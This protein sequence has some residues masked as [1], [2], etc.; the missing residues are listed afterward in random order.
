[1]KNNSV[2]KYDFYKSTPAFAIQFSVSMCLL[3]MFLSCFVII[4]LF[5]DYDETKWGVIADSLCILL[6]LSIYCCFRVS[7]KRNQGVFLSINPLSFSVK[8]K[9]YLWKDIDFIHYSKNYTRGAGSNLLI[10]IKGKI[11]PINI[12]LDA[13]FGPEEVKT[14]IRLFKQYNNRF[15]LWNSKFQRWL[16]E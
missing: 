6:S 15:D 5:P 16:W 10:F 12:M 3:L 2:E 4:I 14:I 9:E 13:Y 8:K 7:K 11:F 1:M